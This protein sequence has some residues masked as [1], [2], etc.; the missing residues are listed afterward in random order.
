MKNN[1]EKK[2]YTETD[3]QIWYD[4]G[5]IAGLLASLVIIYALLA[6]S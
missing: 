5:A 2:L 4:W 1:I 3:L 6:G